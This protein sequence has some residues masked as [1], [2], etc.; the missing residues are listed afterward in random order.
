MPT[1]KTVYK[2]SL[3]QI[4]NQFNL[5]TKVEGYCI[6]MLYTTLSSLSTNSSDAQMAS[7]HGL[8]SAASITLEWKPP[9]ATVPG[10][11]FVLRNAITS[12]IFWRI[13]I[14]PRPCKNVMIVQ[15][16]T[17]N[18]SLPIYHHY[19]NSKGIGYQLYGSFIS[20]KATLL[21]LPS[22]AV[23]INYIKRDVYI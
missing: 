10:S 13:Y 15:A 3:L 14:E 11:R 8:Y 9:A 12:G 2:K 18:A 21:V 20:N 4:H 5:Y 23:L 16:K 19:I 22:S 7:N 6:A 1:R 17:K